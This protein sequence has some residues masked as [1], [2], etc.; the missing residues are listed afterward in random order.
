MLLNLAG[1]DKTVKLPSRVGLEA[2]YYFVI[3]LDS[4]KRTDAVAKED[5]RAFDGLGS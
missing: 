3:R 1:G 4:R 5:V 2:S